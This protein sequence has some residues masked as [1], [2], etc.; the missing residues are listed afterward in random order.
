MSVPS[1]YR[2]WDGKRDKP[3]ASEQHKEKHSSEG[4]RVKKRAV[5]LGLGA[6][7]VPINLG[8]SHHVADFSSLL[9][10]L[11]HHHSSTAGS[12]SVGSVSSDNSSSKKS[13]K[14]KQKKKEKQATKPALVLPTNKSTHSKVRQAKFQSRTEHDMKCIFGTTATFP[15]AA[16]EYDVAPADT[17]KSIK[18][19]TKKSPKKE[20]KD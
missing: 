1:F 14:K 4:L 18:K 17:T 6:T 2:K 9:Q 7:S 12:S 8:S 5:G 16:L 15:S 20:R 19:K 10:H 13:K 11:N 3:L